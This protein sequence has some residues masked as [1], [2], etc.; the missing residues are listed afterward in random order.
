LT[1]F[2][3]DYPVPNNTQELATQEQTPEDD[4]KQSDVLGLDVE[5][6]DFPVQRTDFVDQAAEKLRVFVEEDQLEGAGSLKPVVESPKE[7]N[8]SEKMAYD[9]NGVNGYVRDA[10]D[11]GLDE[12]DNGRGAEGYDGY[13]G[14]F[15]E[16]SGAQEVPEQAPETGRFSS[17]GEEMRPMLR[18]T[19]ESGFVGSM[20]MLNTSAEEASQSEP[21]FTASHEDDDRDADI[22]EEQ[23][24]HPL[25][26]I[27]F[28]HSPFDHAE[29]SEITSSDLHMQS[30]IQ[31]HLELQQ[32][33]D[34]QDDIE[35][36]EEMEGEQ[37]IPSIYLVGDQ[38]GD[39]DDQYQ[40]K[41]VDGKSETNT[42]DMAEQVQDMEDIL[43]EEMPVFTGASIPFTESQDDPAS[44]EKDKTDQVCT[45]CSYI[46][47]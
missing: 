28:T 19:M 39:S 6:P 33:H 43:N 1:N 4:V 25:S 47:G 36:Q 23:V 29:Q 45:R 3:D 42:I 31:A 18:G 46:S 35:H 32:Q 37:P 21:T 44:Q 26:E 15:D 11:Y 10:M 14:D 22:S 38:E 5:V 30:D 34:L 9:Q 8:K 24:T 27:S 13:D 17:Q 41:E 2:D 40:F 20:E 7:N 12:V 16:G